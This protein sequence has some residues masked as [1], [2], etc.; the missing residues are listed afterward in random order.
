MVVLDCNAW[1]EARKGLAMSAP[2]DKITVKRH[3]RRRG[4][5]TAKVAQ[6][7]GLSPLIEVESFKRRHPEK[8]QTRNPKVEANLI[9]TAYAMM[10]HLTGEKAKGPY[11][12]GD[13]EYGK[14]VVQ[15]LANLGADAELREG[16]VR[17]KKTAIYLLS[18]P[19][20]TGVRR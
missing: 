12:F 9:L 6:I 13:E 1:V 19:Q 20:E 11:D 8:R 5:K 18:P 14:D 17:G 2:S 15:E 7:L 10:R 4:G 3:M 16:K